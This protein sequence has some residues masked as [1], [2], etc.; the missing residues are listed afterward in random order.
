MRSN[1]SCL[2]MAGFF[3]S[4]LFTS[5]MLLT[6]TAGAQQRQPAP[7]RGH[8]QAAPAGGHQQP[9]PG[10]GRLDADDGEEMTDE[11]LDK[12]MGNGSISGAIE[13]EEEE[14]KKDPYVEGQNGSIEFVSSLLAQLTAGT[15]PQSITLPKNEAF[16]HL[17]AVYLYCKTKNGICPLI[18]QGLLEVDVIHSHLSHEVA[19]PTLRAF[20]KQWLANAFDKREK[21]VVSTSD[22]V[23]ATEFDEKERPKYL[24]CKA[25]IQGILDQYKGGAPIMS[26]RYGAGKEGSENIRRLKVLLEL[27][28]KKVPNVFVEVGAK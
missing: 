26:A 23:K 21:Y 5:S 14:K 11:E 16:S 28:Q 22:L 12:Q 15:G 20:W 1:R 6:V 3:C 24:N 27:V 4:A 19:C 7:S 10:S 9:S 8:R 2:S 18:L 17:S 13:L 25:T